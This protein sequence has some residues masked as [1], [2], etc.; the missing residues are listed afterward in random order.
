MGYEGADLGAPFLIKLIAAALIFV[1]SAWL[2]ILA[3]RAARTG[4]PPP[5]DLVA[6]LGLAAR[7][8]LIVAIIMAVIAFGA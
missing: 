4:T 6:K 1:I 3:A 7:L 5:P 8:L 2:N